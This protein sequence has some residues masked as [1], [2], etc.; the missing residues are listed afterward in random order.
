MQFRIAQVLPKQRDILYFANLYFFNKGSD[1][2]KYVPATNE[3]IWIRG[4]QILDAYYPEL[5]VLLF[6]FITLIPHS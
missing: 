1:L 2:W 3:W 4:F 5:G 6:L